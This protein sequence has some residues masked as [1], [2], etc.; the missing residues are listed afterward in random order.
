MAETLNQHVETVLKHKLCKL[1][2][3]YRRSL[4]GAK[5]E[6]CSAEEVEK[7]GVVIL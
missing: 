5:S 7:K 6:E 3:S 4:L 1:F 2:D